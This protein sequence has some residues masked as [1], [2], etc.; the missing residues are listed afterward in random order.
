MKLHNT[1]TVALIYGGESS[2]HE[3]SLLSASEVY[4]ELKEAEYSIL[5]FYISKKGVWYIQDEVLDHEGL[6]PITEEDTRELLISPGKGI[7]YKELLNFDVA[8]PITHGKGGEDG[9]LQGLLTTLHIPYIGPSPF[10]SMIGM[11]KKITK[12]MAQEVNIPVVPHISFSY[13]DIDLLLNKKKLSRK[14]ADLVG[15]SDYRK[16]TYR[17]LFD[18][19]TTLLGTHL[20][21]KPEDEGSSIGIEIFLDGD[22]DDFFKRIERVFNFSSIVLVETYI[23][24]MVE[25]ECGV[26]K[27]THF[28]ASDP[29]VILNPKTENPHFLSYTQKYFSPTPFSIDPH[30]SLKETT[31]NL[32]KEYALLV[33]EILLIEGF[34]R[35][36]FFYQKGSGKIY[37][38]EINTI[39][40]LT[41]TSMYP[42]L[43][44]KSGYSLGRLLNLL[45]HQKVERD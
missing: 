8:L 16:E 38:N 39:P 10:S 45:I 1:I 25:V 35:V 15:Y 26:V 23:E 41:K 27:D 11:H 32:I 37:F 9:I 14:I 40:G 31:R 29:Q 5:L 30:Y 6:L 44:K 2:E 7:Y 20:I 18:N 4:K 24:D 42:L 43:M 36:D 17:D 28:V 34:A 12:L 21:L 3:I 33:C 13:E 22:I 19:I